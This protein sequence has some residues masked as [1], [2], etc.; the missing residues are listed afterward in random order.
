MA[1]TGRCRSIAMTQMTIHRQQER[2]LLQYD[3]QHIPL[4]CSTYLVG[5]AFLR[6]LLR[7]K[8]KA[9]G[10]GHRA[11]TAACCGRRQ[12]PACRGCPAQILYG[13]FHD[14]KFSIF[15]T[16]PC[17]NPG[18][19]SAIPKGLSFV[20]RSLCPDLDFSSRRCLLKRAL[21]SMRANSVRR[22]SLSVMK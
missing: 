17:F 4:S 19:R 18:N 2:T 11:D 8:M 9:G 1:L 5:A 10:P 16:E 21:R 20:G 13:E 7:D 6:L 15:V 12:W 3:R 14:W 22:Q